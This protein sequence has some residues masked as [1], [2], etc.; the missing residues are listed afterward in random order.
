MVHMHCL[1]LCII[2][3]SCLIHGVSHWMDISESN[4]IQTKS[5]LVI[6]SGFYS[7]VS[8]MLETLVR[9]MPGH[10][11]LN[12]FVVC[13]FSLWIFFSEALDWRYVH[14]TLQPSAQCIAWSAPCH[15]WTSVSG[16][17]ERMNEQLIFSA[18]PWLTSFFSE[19]NLGMYY[20]LFCCLKETF[21][22]SCFCFF[23]L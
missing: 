4:V 11:T 14:S 9:H 23:C 5:C 21:T 1:A 17:K 16:Y 2:K 6:I 3:L 8:Q 13:I 22:A 18:L 19:H 15:L 20:W 12:A 7:C 10:C